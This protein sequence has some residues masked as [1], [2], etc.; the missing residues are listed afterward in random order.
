T[1][2][3]STTP[4]P[5]AQVFTS[6]I[7][8]EAMPDRPAGYE[9]VDVMVLSDFSPHSVRPAVLRSIATWVASGGV[10]IISAGADYK[11]LQ[12]S[13]YS[14][15]LPVKLTGTASLPGMASLSA[16]G[17]EPFPSGAVSIAKSTIKPRIGSAMLTQ[18][19]VP[20]VAKRSY[21]A[22]K[23]IF[24]AFDSQSQPFRGWNG[25][26][27]FW[28]YLIKTQPEQT[29]VPTA[30]GCLSENGG[31]YGAPGTKAPMSDVVRQDSS[32]KMPGIST[33]G[34]FMLAYLVVLVPVNYMVLKRKRRLEMAWVT[35]P[36]I[37]VAFTLGAYAIGSTMKGGKLSFYEAT[38][39]EGSSNARYARMITDASLFSPAKRNY[40]VKVID[41][42]AL[43]QVIPSRD[44]S[45]PS[46]AYLN[47]APT[48]EQVPM[49]MWSTKEF[50]SVGGMDL[51]GVVK[52][53]LITDGYR[54]QGKITN[55][56]AFQ[57]CDCWVVFRGSSVSLGN[58]P[59]GASAM[60]D[61][62]RGASHGQPAGSQPNPPYIKPGTLSYGLKTHAQYLASQAKTPVLV[63]SMPGGNMFG[64]TGNNATVKSARMC[65]IRLDIGR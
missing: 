10:L 37:V 53:E 30:A 9:T 54:I 7:S 48:I 33:I 12:N 29:F 60:V 42:T 24:V 2:G 16:L 52:S 11:M 58:L 56:T 51:G 59:V 27:E 20:I 46:I 13:F 15:L 1:A 21:G 40:D 65:L 61:M 22:G 36:V 25:Q 45:E 8:T 14:D 32:V 3:S 64:T 41:S 38:I 23:V 39:V 50:E 17:K 34:L 49:S 19:G 62:T 47:D 26:T 57:L 5:E 35:T 44:D 6:S 31:Y 63:G 43:C 18:N 4:S 55:N 28:K